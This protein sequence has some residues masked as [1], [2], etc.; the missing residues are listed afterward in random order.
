MI[1]PV[2]LLLLGS[3]F[4]ATGLPTRAE[5]NPSA[6]TREDVAACAAAYSEDCLLALFLR[7]IET[8][9]DMDLNPW[10]LEKLAERF[11]S[12]HD[13]ARFE[14]VKG[15]LRRLAYR[16]MPTVK[17]LPTYALSM[18]RTAD[19][20]GDHDLAEQLLRIAMIETDSYPR[21]TCCPH[22]DYI[23]E[24]QVAVALARAGQLDVASRRLEE[25]AEEARQPLISEIPP[26]LARIQIAGYQAEAGFA[27]AAFLTILAELDDPD[28]EATGFFDASVDAILSIG[29]VGQPAKA[30]Y[31]LHRVL[32]NV[33]QQ[34]DPKHQAAAAENIAAALNDLGYSNEAL[35][36]AQERLDGAARSRVALRLASTLYDAGDRDGARAALGTAKQYADAASKERPRLLMNLV[37]VAQRHDDISVMQDTVEREGDTRT[38]ESLTRFLVQ[39]YVRAGLPEKAAALLDAIKQEYYSIWGHAKVASGFAKKGALAEAR[40]HVEIAYARA[41]QWDNP[42]YPDDPRMSVVRPLLML[43]E[44]DRARALMKRIGKEEG[45]SAKAIAM[46]RANMGDAAGALRALADDKENE[47]YVR[48]FFEVAE[49]LFGIEGRPVVY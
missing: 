42:H 44:L 10:R 11:E 1:R 19:V 4:T 43:G 8:S 29:K 31:L 3:V 49:T 33:L 14:Q 5:E 36:L 48:A 9:G 13:T 37:A 38:R 20:L 18:A 15:V 46:A 41:W 7:A 25:L 26:V 2:V 34:N 16:S 47:F 12:E 27:Q 17:K 39:A 28:G 24:A 23:T 30:R 40:A 22:H 35:R 6:L 21:N 32:L 45:P